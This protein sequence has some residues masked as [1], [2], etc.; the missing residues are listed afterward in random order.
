MRSV[1]VWV[2]FGFIPPAPLLLRYGLNTIAILTYF[3][4]ITYLSVLWNKKI[5]YSCGIFTAWLE[6]VMLGKKSV[7]GTLVDM[8][9]RGILP[10]GSIQVNGDL[11][12]GTIKEKAPTNLA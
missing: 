7:L 5:D 1:L 9:E 2:V 6:D 8:Q 4:L 3:A 12:N 11:E 10:G